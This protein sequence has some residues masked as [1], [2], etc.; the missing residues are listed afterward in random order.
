[1]AIERVRRA[2]SFDSFISDTEEKLA[3]DDSLEEVPRCFSSHNCQM[4]KKRHLNHFLFME[5]EVE[6]FLNDSRLW[7]SDFLPLDSCQSLFI[8]F[9]SV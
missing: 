8:R 1:M 3:Q 6:T 4:T 9:W 5:H 7:S 2:L